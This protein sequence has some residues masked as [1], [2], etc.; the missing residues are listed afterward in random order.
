MDLSLAPMTGDTFPG[1]TGPHATYA[2][3]IAP[4]SGGT[5]Y[6]WVAGWG[7]DDNGNSVNV[8]VGGAAVGV[9]DSFPTSLNNAP[10]WVQMPGSVT[11]A[12]GATN[13]IDLWGI[14]DGTQIFKI[15]LT[16]FDDFSPAPDG[17]AQSACS[18]AAEPHVPPGLRQCS[19][20]IHR[21]NFEGTFFEVTNAWSSEDQ[22]T[23]F[24]VVGS[25]NSNRGASF[26][27]FGGRNP[28]IFQNVE[29]PDWLD[30]ETTAVFKYDVGVYQRGAPSVADELRVALSRVSDGA[31][32]F[33]TVLADGADVPD[34]NP[35]LNNP[36][37][38]RT[39]QEVDIFANVNPLSKMAPGDRLQIRFYSPD[40]N[41]PPSGPGNSTEFYLD[42]VNLEFCSVEAEPETLPTNARLSGKTIRQSGEPI[43]GAKVWAYA[44]NG[45]VYETFTIQEGQYGFF[46]LPPGEYLIYAQVTDPSG[47]L[48]Q[49]ETVS[50]G[51]GDDLRN[52]ILVLNTS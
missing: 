14:E 49:S 27:A 7:P 39:N 8:G 45:P 15:L 38:W 26:P 12:G 21:G 44:V 35:V 1:V 52:I 13:I 43:I 36:E 30:A 6:V 32:L 22:A 42:N 31:I 19:N 10:G 18:I 37:D 47:T 34:L 50:V 3:D 51:P 40:T 28:A 5:Y 11:L 29:A 33:E 9:I 25:A 48:F 4:D 24:S 16:Q 17:M 20:P 41:P 2:V 46:N 23:P